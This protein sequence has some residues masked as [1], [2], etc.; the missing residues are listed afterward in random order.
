MSTAALLNHVDDTEVTTGGEDDGNASRHSM[1]QQEVVQITQLWYVG[2][3]CYLVLTSHKGSWD[4][5]KPQLVVGIC[6]SVLRGTFK[7]PLE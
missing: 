6:S 2:Q 3:I 7:A 5:E 1:L 4:H